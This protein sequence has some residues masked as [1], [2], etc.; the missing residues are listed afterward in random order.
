ML[1]YEF[2]G[3]ACECDAGRAD[4]VDE[5]DLT[6]CCRAPFVGA[7]AAVGCWDISGAGERGW[8]VG[9]CGELVALGG[10]VC[11]RRAVYFVTR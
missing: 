2:L 10:G 4:A 5:K 6:A 8:W 3:K 11:Q 7:Y 1:F 9:A